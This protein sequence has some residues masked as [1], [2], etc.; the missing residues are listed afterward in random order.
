MTDN[1]NMFRMLDNMLN[2]IDVVNLVIP[3][4][5][6]VLLGKILL[7]RKISNLQTKENHLNLLIYSCTL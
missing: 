1:K 5:I 4:V 2:D 6:V 7:R 3:P